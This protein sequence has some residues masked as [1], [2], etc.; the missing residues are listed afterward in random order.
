M[1]ASVVDADVASVAGGAGADAFF[2]GVDD[3]PEVG[4][5]SEAGRPSKRQR[6]APR[7]M[8]Q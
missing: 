4:D 6:A 7:N 3:E 5:A 1:A 8:T 2:H